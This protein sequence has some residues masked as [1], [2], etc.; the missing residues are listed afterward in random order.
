MPFYDIAQLRVEII[1][2]K[3]RTEKQAIPYLSKNQDES[4]KAD[5]V[6]NVDDSRVEAA[7]KE[8]PE[9]NQG[10]WEYMLTGS[11]FYTDLIKFNGILLHSSCVVVDGV[12]Y[13]F[14]ADSGTGKSTHT[15]LWLKHFGDRAYILND[16]KPAIRIID[17][18]PYACG[19]P[20]SG[21]YDYSTPAVVPLA[22]ICFLSRSETNQIKKAD[23]GKAIYNIFSQTVRR[24]GESRMNMLMDNL[25]EIFKLVP[26]YDL[27]CNMSDDAVLCSYNAM[28]KE[29]S[30]FE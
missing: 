22:G 24:L 4:L 7:I 2:P 20:W 27:G 3:G 28:K 25:N 1:E 5:I 29:M 26:I 14:S 10:D 15:Q 9:L 23:T 17:G 12:A 8:H 6:I 30:D 21:K 19:T 16:D 13:A 18:K 11:D